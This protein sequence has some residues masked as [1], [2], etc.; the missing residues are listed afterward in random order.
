MNNEDE[1][2][3]GVLNKD[4][5]IY[6]GRKEGGEG[7]REDNKKERMGSVRWYVSVCIGTTKGRLLLWYCGGWD[8]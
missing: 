1:S 6:E 2:G 7:I 3:K 8:E 4:L 5:S